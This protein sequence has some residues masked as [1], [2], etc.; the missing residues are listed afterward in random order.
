MSDLET[1]IREVKE[2][3]KTAAAKSGRDEREITVV[4]ASKLQ[5]AE[6]V[7]QALLSGIKHFGE[8]KVQEAE[9]K[10][11][12]ITAPYDGFH[13]IGH[14]QTN[15]VKQLLLLNPCL[16]HSVDSLHL[17]K[18][19]SDEAVKLHKRQDVLLEVNTSGEASKYGFPILDL[20]AG[21]IAMTKMF[22]LRVKG[23]MTVARMSDNPEDSR[24]DFR[25]LKSLAECLAR[26]NLPDLDMHW[27]SMGMSNDFEIAIEEGSNLVRLGTAIFGPRI[28]PEKA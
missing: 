26:H 5:S 23:L 6:K 13:F 18:A 24:K 7:N 10:L 12:L 27:L 11:P 21:A 22:G 19:I 25:L 16:I 20:E 9:Q 14:L 3:I 4:A 28:K 15:K 17:A 8:N 1:K 2:R